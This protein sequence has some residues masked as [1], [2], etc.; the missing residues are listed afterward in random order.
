MLVLV[1]WR[2]HLL[3]GCCQCVQPGVGAPQVHLPCPALCRQARQGWNSP[4]DKSGFGEDYVFNHETLWFLVLDDH[5]LLSWDFTVFSSI[6][7]C[8]LATSP[9]A[10]PLAKAESMTLFF[11][12]FL[13]TLRMESTMML[14]CFNIWIKVNGD[15]F[16]HKHDPDHFDY[17]QWWWK[18][19]TSRN[20]GTLWKVV[21]E[22]WG[23]R[24]TVWHWA[25]WKL[26]KQLR[27]YTI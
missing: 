6:S 25:E 2:Q 5:S 15:V 9:A 10:I 17:D 21:C 23:S 14:T 11:D 8:T 13:N 4:G 24:V 12:T 16:L 22:V 19:R 27:T 26:K 3:W 7:F 1:L 20:V 18:T